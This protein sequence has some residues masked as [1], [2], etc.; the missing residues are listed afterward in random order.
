MVYKKILLGAIVLFLIATL[1]YS[2]PEVRLKDIARVVGVRGN[3]LVGYGLVVGL[4]GTGDSDKTM[5]TFQSVVNMMERLGMTVDRE[6]MEVE[7]VAAVVVTAELPPFARCGDR[8][9]VTVSSLGDAESLEG[10]VLLQTPLLAANNQVYAVAQGKVSIGGSNIN[11]MGG[12]RN[13][14]TVGRI[15]KGAII[16]REITSPILNEDKKTISLSLNTPDFTTASRVVKV[17]NGKFTPVT[18]RAIDASL[19]EI[20]IPREFEEDVIGFIATLEDLRITPDT[21][22]KV[23]VNERTGTVVAGGDAKISKVAVAH[24][25]LSLRVFERV[26]VPG[27]EPRIEEKLEK[28]VIFKEST[29]VDD[30]VKALN[31]VGATPRDLV[32][33]LQAIDAAGA[34]HAELIIM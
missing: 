7:N 22:I 15:P 5:F 29:T 21:T 25:N 13:Y 31:A 23:V 10:G 18:S 24:G 11:P 28:V 17:I 8:I 9:D 1:S 2:Q 16:E 34:L 32:A 12:L 6:E 20:E 4:E 30:L 19:I 27:E 33:I 3:Q 26:K 14:P